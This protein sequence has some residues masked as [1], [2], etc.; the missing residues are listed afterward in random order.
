MY[1]S[2]RAFGE[3]NSEIL[4]KGKVFCSPLTG[5]SSACKRKGW[6]KKEER[7]QHNNSRSHGPVNGEGVGQKKKKERPDSESFA[8]REKEHA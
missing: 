6:V 7:V 4:L 2:Y 3:K 1:A 8:S 5:G